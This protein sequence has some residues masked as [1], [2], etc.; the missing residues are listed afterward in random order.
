M[1]Y[2]NLFGEKTT[3]P[4]AENTQEKAYFAV[5]RAQRSQITLV[6]MDENGEVQRSTVTAEEVRGWLRQKQP[7]KP[8]TQ[9]WTQEGKNPL[10]VEWAAGDE[11]LS[12]V[13]GEYHDARMRKFA[14]EDVRS[15]HS[16][17]FMGNPVYMARYNE[18]KQGRGDV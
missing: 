4:G 5:G 1:E 13:R 6:W 18:L 14:E 12:F 2:H 11:R 15:G 8:T 17:E 9:I 7:K 16:P 3:E 10:R